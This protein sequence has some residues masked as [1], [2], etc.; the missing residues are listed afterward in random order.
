[1]IIDEHLIKKITEL[2]KLEMKVGETKKISEQLAKI[3]EHM[4][5]LK[6]V[7]VD[8]VE[9]MFHGCIDQHEL[10]VDE[11]VVFNSDVIAKGFFSVPNIMSGE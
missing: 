10:R 2:S 6:E 11:P 9:P 5:V 4:N 1:M 7:N 3:L 8:G